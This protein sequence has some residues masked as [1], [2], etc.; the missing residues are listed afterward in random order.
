MN[1]ETREVKGP[2]DLRIFIN[3][4]ASIHKGHKNWVPPIYMDDRQ[5]FNPKKNEF[6]SYSDTILLL[7]RIENKVVGR[8]MGII[9]HKY[10]N[11]YNLK[12]GRFAFLETY[13]DYDV[14]KT[15]IKYIEDWA[16]Q[17]G[18]DKLVGPLGFSDKDPQG[19]LIEGFDEPVAIATNCNFPYLVDYI[20]KAGYEK[21]VDLMVY[22]LD[23]PEVIPEFYR[24][25]R[26]RASKNNHTT[27]LVSFSSR[28]QLKKY[29]KPVF[30]LVNETF[31]DIYAFAPLS[32]KE[33]EEFANRYLILLDPRFIKVVENN[34]GEVVAC[35]LAMPDISEGIKKCKGRLIPF[36]I[37]QVFRAQKKTKQLNLLLGGIKADYRNSGLDTIMGISLL[38]E[39]RNRGMKVIDSHL[40]LE[41]NTKMR[42]EME[43]MGGV[44]YKRFRI[45]QKAL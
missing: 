30:N 44:V 10:N 41:T 8:V 3:L 20:E 24:R 40:E 42:A 36:G 39:A 2:R 4:P 19:F 33:M 37:F 5:F 29:V 27:R 14:A 21:K 34:M 26:D 45:F 15:L 35:I 16:K 43:K 28:K 31:K 22:K 12:E 6:F 38:E 11:A 25:I 23:I 9:N 32:E 7:A 13:Q 17:K 18:M 1:I